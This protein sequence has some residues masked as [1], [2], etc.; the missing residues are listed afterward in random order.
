MWQQIKQW[1]TNSWMAAPDFD[2]AMAHIGWAWATTLTFAYLGTL[3]AYYVAVG[4]FG[5]YALVK[6][7]VYDANFEEPNQTFKMNTIDVITYAIGLAISGCVVWWK[8]R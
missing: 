7:Y 8:N 6:E 3:Q 5:G 1:L 2:A 4:I